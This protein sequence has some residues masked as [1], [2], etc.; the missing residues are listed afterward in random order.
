MAC[1]RVFQEAPCGLEKE[2]W[3]VKK[4]SKLEQCSETVNLVNLFEM[5]RP[6]S[7]ECQS[8]L[9]LKHF[10]TQKILFIDAIYLSYCLKKSSFN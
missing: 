8:L 3:L 9:G 7:Q 2:A 4:V 1:G 6:T 5:S 10:A